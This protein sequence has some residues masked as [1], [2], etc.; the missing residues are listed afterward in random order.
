MD[1]TFT[2]K[3]NV[4]QSFIHVPLVTRGAPDDPM[5]PCSHPRAPVFLGGPWSPRGPPGNLG[6][7]SR[8]GGPFLGEIVGTCLRLAKSC[9]QCISP[10]AT[11]ATR[12]RNAI[13]SSA[14]TTSLWFTLLAPA[15]T[16]TRLVRRES[17]TTWLSFQRTS[18]TSLHSLPYRLHA[19]CPPVVVGRFQ[20][21][22]RRTER[23]SWT[24]RL[25]Q[26]MTRPQAPS[27]RAQQCTT[28]TVVESTGVMRPLVPTAPRRQFFRL[29]HDLAHAPGRPLNTGVGPF[30]VT[31][32]ETRR[33]D[34]NSLVTPVS[35]EQGSP[36]HQ[37]PAGQ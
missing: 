4:C 16:G 30:R 11:S 23:R 17:W 19:A 25:L 15:L 35:K 32:H 36:S 9:W 29:M 7:P 20:R 2:R 14:L 24:A 6:A 26:H 3:K 27:R 33:P 12:C 1:K 13:W 34:V 10:C 21:A 28:A 8:A 31:R 37:V 22:R 18:V 5:G